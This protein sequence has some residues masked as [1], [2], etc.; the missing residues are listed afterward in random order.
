MINLKKYPLITGTLVLTFAGLISRCIGFGYRLFISQAF[1]EESMGLF[2]LISPVVMIAFSLTGAGM[3]TAISRYT[4]SC[5]ACHKPD[6]ARRYLWIGSGLCLLLSS[7]YAI[8]IYGQADF[9]S[10]KLFREPRLAP[11]LRITA[12]TFPLSSFHCCLNGYFYGMKDVRIPSLTQLAEQLTRTGGVFLLYLLLSRKGQPTIALTAWG[13]VLG[14][15]ASCA[16]S[17]LSYRSLY[18]KP[19]QRP[20]L[21]SVKARSSC[22]T[23]FLQLTGMAIPLSCN[24]L[25]VNLLQSVEAISIPQGLKEFGYSTQTAL[26]IYGVLTGM[27]F[28][29]ILF[30]SAF[31]QS[32]SVLLLPEVT[33]AAAS[34][35]REQMKTTIYRSISASIALGIFCGLGFFIFGPLAGEL[36]FSSLLAGTFIRQLSFLCPFLYL[37]ATLSSILHGLKKAGLSLF[38]NVFSLLLRLFFTLYFIP[39][40]GIV[41]YLW[42]LLCSELLSAGLHLLFIQKSIE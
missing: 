6:V 16:I 26:S 3:Q 5:V 25:I 23:L 8:L 19:A 11:L 2:Q 31:T 27:A 13:M 17:F 15:I 29:L 1:G 39:R 40:V 38:I 30:P 41:G 36:L 22:I 9:L 7:L 21:S 12:F 20:S 42:G 18:S 28:S 24:R 32:A 35:H 4:A 10:C 33:Q 14:E 34:S 37:H